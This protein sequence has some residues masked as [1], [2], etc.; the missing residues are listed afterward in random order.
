MVTFKVFQCIIQFQI[1]VSSFRGSDA[2]LHNWKEV[3]ETWTHIVSKK[4]SD[5]KNYYWNL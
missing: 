4:R 3:I 2:M 5:K 1:T